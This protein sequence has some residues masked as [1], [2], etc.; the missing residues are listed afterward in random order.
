MRRLQFK[1]VLEKSAGMNIAHNVESAAFHFPE[2]VAVIE[3]DRYI[4]D[5]I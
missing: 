2:N 5:K 1:S 4:Y 3:G